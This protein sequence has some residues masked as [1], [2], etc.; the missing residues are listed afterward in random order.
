MGGGIGAYAVINDAL[1]ARI[2]VDVDGN[3][4]KGGYL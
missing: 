1:I 3:A 2:V 4:A